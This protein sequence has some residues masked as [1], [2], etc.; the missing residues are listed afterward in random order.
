[1]AKARLTADAARKLA[2]KTIEEK[3]D[4]ILVAIEDF[5]KNGKRRLDA[6]GDYKE[7]RDLWSTEGYKDSSQY[8]EAKKALEDLGYTVSYYYDDSTQ[9]GDAYTIIEW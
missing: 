2:G 4:S 6:P 1:M 5:A 3:V 7:D 9:L 8:K